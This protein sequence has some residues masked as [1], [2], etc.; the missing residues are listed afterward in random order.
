ME[1]D[2]KGMLHSY[3]PGEGKLLHATAMTE[4]EHEA[5]LPFLQQHGHRTAHRSPFAVWFCPTDEP[6]LYVARFTGYLRVLDTPMTLARGE[7]G[8]LL[9]ESWWAAL[10]GPLPLSVSAVPSADPGSLAVAG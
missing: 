6:D 7:G 3:D 9:T 5:W 1:R 2:I 10:I 4:E 8:R